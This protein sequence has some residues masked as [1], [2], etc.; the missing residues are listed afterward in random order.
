MPETLQTFI[1][2]FGV[3]LIAVLLGIVG[4]FV[5][6]LINGM[7]TFKVE[8]TAAISELSRTMAAIRIDLGED[9][10]DAKARIKMLEEF[11][12]TQ[13]RKGGN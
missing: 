4:F 5:V 1:W 10:T 7:D 12:C 2:L 3:G 13:R 9:L 8:V 6:R 11:G